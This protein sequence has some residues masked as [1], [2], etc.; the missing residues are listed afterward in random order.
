MHCNKLLIVSSSRG[1]AVGLHPALGK[2]PSASVQLV[3][4]NITQINHSE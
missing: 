3:M 1:R 4:A 2:Q